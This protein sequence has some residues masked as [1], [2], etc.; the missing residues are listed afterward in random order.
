MLLHIVPHNIN[1]SKLVIPI[2][3][4]MYYEYS[5]HAMVVIFQLCIHKLI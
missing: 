3:L 4:S 2:T 5:C 1:L